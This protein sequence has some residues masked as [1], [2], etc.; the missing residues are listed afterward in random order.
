VLA[1]SETRVVIEHRVLD[2]HGGVNAIAL[3]QGGL[4]DRAARAFVPAAELMTITGAAVESPPL[5]A[6][7]AAFL[8]AEEALKATTNREDASNA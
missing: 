4:Y 3:V 2:D 6:D 8:T 7:V 5:R 1:W